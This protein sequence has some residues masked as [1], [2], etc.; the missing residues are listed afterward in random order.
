M[1]T[2]EILKTNVS[3]LT[4]EQASKIETVVNNALGQRIGEIHGQYDA[5]IFTATGR[6]KPAGVKTYEH[7]KTIL[8][9]LKSGANG[10]EFKSQIETLKAEKQTLADQIKSGA[11][12]E[13]L[14][15][16]LAAKDSMIA[17]LK[18]GFATE[19]SEWEKQLSERDQSTL[20]SKSDNEFNLAFTGL[21]KKDYSTISETLQKA[22]F[23]QAVRG[24]ESE[25]KQQVENGVL[26]FKDKDGKTKLNKA[27]EPATAAELLSERK[28]VQD[29]LSTGVQGAGAGTGATGTND[30]VTVSIGAAKTKTEATEAIRAG[31]FAEGLTVESPAFQSR[32]TEAYKTNEVSK[33]PTR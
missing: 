19:K 20:K 25:Y 17:Q 26:I 31:L 32:F 18:T 23:A 7:L 30:K 22:A 11:G 10:D 28:E 12:N 4:E 15:A 8:T 1:I 9:E 21:K 6:Q 3:D 33:L 16:Q 29:L 5:D 24:I 2:K 27:F 14:N 13:A